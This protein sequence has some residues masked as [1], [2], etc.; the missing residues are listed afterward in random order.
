MALF[1]H[2][3]EGKTGSSHHHSDGSI[4]AEVALPLTHSPALRL[5][6][7]S[8]GN[9]FPVLGL[10]SPNSL[11]GCSHEQSGGAFHCID[12]PQAPFRAHDADGSRKT[13]RGRRIRSNHGSA[14]VA[15]NP[16]T[17]PGID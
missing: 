13:V 7:L 2:G 16:H 15:D 12:Q 3:V 1:S 17:G 5:L 4:R 6:R 14:A 11:L 8:L 10:K 9:L